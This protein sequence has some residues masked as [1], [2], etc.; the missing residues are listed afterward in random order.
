MRKRV[1]GNTIPSLLECVNDVIPI[2]AVR[3]DV[4]PNTGTIGSS[5]FGYNYMEQQVWH[6]PTL[7]ECKDMILDWFNEQID[8]SILSGFVW[9]DM[10]VW[11]SQENQFNYKAAFDLAVQSDGATL[12][13]TFK[14]GPVDA[15]VYYEFKT[16]EDL[17]DFYTSCMAYVT[18]QLK[19]GWIK[20]DGFDWA[21]YCEV[22]KLK[23]IETI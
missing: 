9:K 19:A 5:A 12:P 2:Y 8:A 16:V 13:V 15:P 21:P 20:K 11:L 22:S 23:E 7:D 17:T 18:S 4:N 10:E 6:K 3:W 14:F 1:N